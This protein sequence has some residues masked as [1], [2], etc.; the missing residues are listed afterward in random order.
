MAEFDVTQQD[1]T[2][3]PLTLEEMRRA[4]PRL[5]AAFMTLGGTCALLAQWLNVHPANANSPSACDLAAEWLHCDAVMGL[6]K[7]L[8][9][10]QADVH[11]VMDEYS[12]EPGGVPR[13]VLDVSIMVSGLRHLFTAGEL[14]SEAT[15]ENALS[16]E[17]GALVCTVLSNLMERIGELPLTQAKLPDEQLAETA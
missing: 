12:D 6:G 4:K 9:S 5:D 2:T 14:A 13:D 8:E 15:G 11:A 17:A 3:D 16:A 7:L 10:A 1:T